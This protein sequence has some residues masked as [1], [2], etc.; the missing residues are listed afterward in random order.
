MLLRTTVF[1]LVLFLS[2]GAA[3]AQDESWT[4]F[5]GT[6][7]DNH[8]ASTGL[9]KEWPEGGPKLLWRAEGLGAGLSNVVFYGDK[10]YTMGDIGPDSCI[11]ALE[12]DGGK[13]LWETAIGD[14]GAVGGY[15]GPKGTPAVD[16]KNVFGYSQFGDFGCVDAETGKL[17]W[18]GN[19]VNEFGGKHQAMWGFSSSPIFFE[20]N[21]IIPVGGNGGTYMAFTKEGKRPWR[22][23]ELKDS[24]PY[25]TPIVAEIGGVKQLILLGDTGVSGVDAK[26]GELLWVVPR[27]F[28]RGALCSDPVYYKD[29]IVFVSAAYNTGMNGYK[30]TKDGD[31]FKAEEIYANR[32]MQNQ[33]GGIIL[34]GDYVYFTTDSE[35][36]CVDVRNGDVKWQNRSVGKGS[37][38]YA[39]GHLIVRDEKQGT[40]GLVEATPEGYREKGRFTQPDR[41]RVQSWTYP[42][43]Y[44]GKLYI[45]DQDT[46]FC[47]DLRAEK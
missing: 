45:R 3:F 41:T 35:L 28:S 8:S 2:L 24:A 6:N 34:L 42:V 23:S 10:I 44:E 11:I 5:R 19:V 33:H 13:K 40:I 37:L 16:G 18:C 25:D 26:T 15:V 47:Y 46:L 32:Q 27:A 22:S 1:S 39:D 14:S 20:D 4:M 9:L 31:K 21:V 12:K 30:V 38:T 17:K 43:V 36:V 29:G 7:R